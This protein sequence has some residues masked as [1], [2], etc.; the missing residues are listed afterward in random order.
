LRATD[1]P[2]ETRNRFGVRARVRLP[3]GLSLEGEGIV[4][5]VARFG[6]DPHSSRTNWRLAASVV[7]RAIDEHLLA[8]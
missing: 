2:A 5:H 3:L 4:E 8:L 7:Y 6:F 1:N